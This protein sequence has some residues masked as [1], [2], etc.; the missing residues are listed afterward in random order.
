MRFR[1]AG[2]LDCVAKD[3]VDRP[4]GLTKVFAPQHRGVRLV[5]LRARKYPPFGR[6]PPAPA[7]QVSSGDGSLDPPFHLL[8][9][10]T[11]T[12]FRGRRP[13]YPVAPP[14]RPPPPHGGAPASRT[15][16]TRPTIH[17]PP[18]KRGGRT[19]HCLHRLVGEDTAAGPIVRGRNVNV[20]KRPEL[21]W[22]TQHRELLRRNVSGQVFHKDHV[23]RIV[24]APV[25][26]GRGVRWPGCGGHFLVLA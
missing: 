1:T 2:R 10:F 7:P 15:E 11:L 6:L 23:A 21:I 19:R 8:R 14:P 5:P 16:E 25:R 13:R 18:L 20:Q 24:H 17:L 4:L 12:L 9:A 26:M 22:I 3:A